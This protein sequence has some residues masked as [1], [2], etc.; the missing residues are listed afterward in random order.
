M[1][2]GLEFELGWRD[3]ID[4]FQYSVTANFSTLKNEVLSLA[5]GATPQYKTDASSTNYKI[6]TAFEEGHSIWYLNGFIYEGMDANGDPIY[7]D[8]SG[9][10]QIGT[11]D[12]VDIGQ[13]TPSHTYGINITAAWKGFDFMLNG[14]GQG[15]NYI[16]P[17]LHRTGFKNG[18]KYYLDEARTPENPGGSIPHPEKI[19][20]PDVP[21]WSSTGNRFSGAYFRIKQLQLGYTIPANITKKVAISN[22]RLY[23]S[24]DDFFTI[25]KYPGLDPETASTNN[26][27]GAGLDWGSYPTMKKLI[28]G[29]NVTF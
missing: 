3:R 7:K 23:V 19:L 13:T 12:M 20:S 8:V 14:Y 22:F 9:D 28:L 1:N 29:V 4:D 6:R 18:L 11:D 5:E 10:G 26:F 25:T 16:V 21:F 15:G 24:L 17:V 27:S 2:K